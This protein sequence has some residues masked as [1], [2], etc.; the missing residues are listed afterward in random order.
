MTEVVI[1]NDARVVG[2]TVKHRRPCSRCGTFDNVFITYA[3]PLD[4]GGQD[5]EWN[6]HILCNPCRRYRKRQHLEPQVVHAEGVKA[7]AER[8]EHLPKSMR[9]EIEGRVFHDVKAAAKHWRV[10]LVTM[11]RWIQEGRNGAKRLDR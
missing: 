10:S 1:D 8:G 6:W 2:K 7:A 5:S 3:V 11:Y 9:V 4:R